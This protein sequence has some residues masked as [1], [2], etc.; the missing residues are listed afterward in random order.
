MVQVIIQLLQM[1]TSY[2]NYVPE[3]M[4]VLKPLMK[5]LFRLVGENPRDLDSPVPMKEQ[6]TNAIGK[7]RLMQAP[8]QLSQ[9][10][11][12]EQAGVEAGGGGGNA[13]QQLSVVQ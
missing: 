6:L 5:K 2:R 3:S 4:N 1:I 11:G 12:G 13:A 8:P 9:E 10:L 7:Q